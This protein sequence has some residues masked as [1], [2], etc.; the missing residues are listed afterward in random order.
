MK[1]RS[2]CSTTQ[3]SSPQ[4]A[5][6]AGI[7]TLRGTKL[8]QGQTTGIQVNIADGIMEAR[9]ILCALDEAERIREGQGG[10]ADPA[11]DRVEPLGTDGT[12]DVWKPT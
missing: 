6:V 4:A 12:K 8:L 3:C 5:V 1:C 7:F 9:R 10:V 11:E 2:S